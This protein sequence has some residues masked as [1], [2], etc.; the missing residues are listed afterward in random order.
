MK[1]RAI[2][3]TLGLQTLQ[4]AL[5]L[6]G[7]SAWIYV[8]S[9]A[10]GP[11]MLGK[12][13]AVLEL[14]AIVALLAASC[15]A[16]RL[17]TAVWRAPPLRMLLQTGV[18]LAGVVVAC[19]VGL[20]ELPAWRA[21]AGWAET[22]DQ[23]LNSG[24]GGWAAG[25]TILAGFLWWR[26][27]G[28]GGSPADLEAVGE[29]F[30][31]GFAALASLLVVTSIA[32]EAVPI[33]AD[34]AIMATLVLVF[35]GLM[36]VALARIVEV[37][38]QRQLEGASRPPLAPWLWLLLGVIGGLLAATLLLAQLLTFD[39][40]IALFETVRGPLG[41]LF[42]AIATIIAVPVG[43]VIH[44]LLF[45]LS[46]ASRSDAPRKPPTPG[47]LEWMDRLREQE[48]LALSP[49]LVLAMKLGLALVLSIA[50]VWLVVRALRRLWRRWEWDGVEE[51]RDFVWSWPGLAALPRWFWGWLRRLRARVRL[52]TAEGLVDLG[53]AGRVRG[54][55][56]RFL[57]LGVSA[58]WARRDVETPLEYEGRLRAESMPG[59]REVRRITESYLP[60]RYGPP[61]SEAVDAD[62]V[63]AAL[64][65]LRT[66]WRKR[67]RLL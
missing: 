25:S 5:I 29:R 66:L 12:A 58:G 47:D 10:G 43:F 41:D 4:Y 32:G 35:C 55:Y 21:G 40:V 30:Q 19:L 7:E 27:V 22:S 1:R 61:D 36:G 2:P 23:L 63:E 62:G 8:W 49:E 46:L 13:G 28:L 44:A 11:W 17:A 37:T 34:R 45:L 20:A 54:L 60:A 56:R 53:A 48:E 18:G 51:D 38:E 52:W 15:L 50:M 6:A 33:P 24:F 16:A 59:G 64:A 42:W 65:S 3:R 39:R 67:R 31:M 14:P 57:L 9:L 26:G